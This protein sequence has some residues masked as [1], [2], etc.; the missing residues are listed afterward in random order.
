MNSAIRLYHRFLP[1]QNIATN[2]LYFVCLVAVVVG[3]V[4]HFGAVKG[5]AIG[6]ALYLHVSK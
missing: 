5:L 1:Y 3:A 6:A 2:I 4:H